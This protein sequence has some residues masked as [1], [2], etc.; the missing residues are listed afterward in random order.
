VIE[1]VVPLS[2]YFTTLWVSTTK[3]SY[4]PSGRCASVFICHVFIGVWDMLV[5]S[6]RVEVEIGTFLD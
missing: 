3:E 5:D 2:E 4:D 1:E 6:D